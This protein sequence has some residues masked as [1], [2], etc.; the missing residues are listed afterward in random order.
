M[1]VAH[2]NYD[3]RIPSFRTAARCTPP[4]AYVLALGGVKGGS[5]LITTYRHP[6]QSFFCLGSGVDGCLPLFLTFFPSSGV[7]ALLL[8]VCPTASF[9]TVSSMVRLDRHRS[10]CS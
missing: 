6:K 1:A 5:S 2:P 4:I 3:F 10:I 8:T 7:A 9:C